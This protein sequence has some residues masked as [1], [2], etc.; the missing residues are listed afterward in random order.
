[1]INSTLST[2]Y[3]SCLCCDCDRN[4]SPRV[5]SLRDPSSLREKPF[6]S[7]ESL[8]SKF[9]VSFHNFSPLTTDSSL[10]QELF[11]FIISYY[12]ISMLLSPR[13]SRFSTL[14]LPGHLACSLFIHFMASQM[15]ELSTSHFQMQC[16]LFSLPAQVLVGV[17]G[18][19]PPIV[20]KGRTLDMVLR[21]SSCHHKMILN[22]IAIRRNERN[23]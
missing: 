6:P 15:R 8:S 10:I 1:M 5:T 13:K 19:L 23:L 21:L 11:I 17:F 9:T 14:C 16:F 22:F 4:D 7:W 2:Y 20:N 12:L 3:Y 18:V